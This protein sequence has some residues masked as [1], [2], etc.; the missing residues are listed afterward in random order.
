MGERC[1]EFYIRLYVKQVTKD[2]NREAMEAFLSC[3]KDQIVVLMKR[4]LVTPITKEELWS[5]LK[6]MVKGKAPRPNGVIV[7]FFLVCGWSYVKNTQ[8]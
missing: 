3:M 8:R 5:I 6:A 1:K 7:E 2:N 4:R